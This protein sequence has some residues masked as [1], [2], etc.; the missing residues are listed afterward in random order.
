MRSIPVAIVWELL[1]RGRWALIAGFLGANLLPLLIENALKMQGGVE[2]A[3]PAQVMMHIMLV[4]ISALMFGAA[5]MSAQGNLSRLYAAPIPTSTL[6]AWHL[7]PA[8]L[9]L[10]L[11]SAASTLLLNALFPLDWPVWGPALFSAV[12]IAAVYAALWQ[13]EKTGWIVIFLTGISMVLGLW[14]KSRHGA[15]FGPVESLHYW[16]EVTPGEVLT[17]VVMGIASYFAAIQGVAR[18]RRGDTLPPLGIVALLERVFD[19]P[20]EPGPPFLTPSAAQFWSIWRQKGWWMPIC[21]VFGMIVGLSC[22]L[23]FSRKSD[24]LVMGFI[25]GGGLLSGLGILAAFTIGNCGPSDANFDIGNFAATRPMTTREMSRIILSALL[26]SVAYSWTIWATG[27]AC[28][29]IIL[30]FLGVTPPAE[31][32]THAI[33]WYIP[34]TLLGPWIVASLGVSLGLTGRAWIGV[35]L[36]LLLFPTMIAYIVLTDI[37]LSD[38][39]QLI[40]GRYLL[41]AAG[42][43]FVLYTAGAYLNAHRLALIDAPA[44]YR[45][46]LVWL[47]ASLVVVGMFRLQP[48]IPISGYIV[49][50]GL[51]ALVVSPFPTVPLAL[52]WNRVR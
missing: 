51:L 45:A 14:Y 19:P 49:V 12:A 52:G 10:F 5:V 21:V 30:L 27:F 28:V 26:R 41:S 37:F 7:F 13:S 2:S 31:I 18:S 23:L 11:G 46:A 50:V 33:W 8:M 4:Q 24:D 20:P 16:R 15:L 9:F 47:V 3:D 1:Y 43:L 44:L 38:E 48:A 42:V 36:C 17:L 32:D 40:L 29:A 6:V 22:W 39:S 34:A 25:G 35:V